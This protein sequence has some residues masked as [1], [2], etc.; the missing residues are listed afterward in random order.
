MHKKIILNKE[1]LLLEEREQLVNYASSYVKESDKR[2][3]ADG[4]ELI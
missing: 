4:R 1:Q 3:R 2:S